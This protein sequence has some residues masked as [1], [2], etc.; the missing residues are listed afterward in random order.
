MKTLIIVFRADAKRRSKKRRIKG[1][2]FLGASRR[3]NSEKNRHS[4]RSCGLSAAFYAQTI[5]RFN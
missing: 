1:V 2:V 5:N 3:R 4:L